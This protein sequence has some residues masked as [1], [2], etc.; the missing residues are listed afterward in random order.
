[1]HIYISGKKYIKK[2]I[3]MINLKFW[4]MVTIGKGGRNR[5]GQ[6]LANNG[7]KDKSSVPPT[8]AWAI[9]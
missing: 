7:S 8:Y 9:S 3:G 1:M 4:I 5:L 6:G 2:F